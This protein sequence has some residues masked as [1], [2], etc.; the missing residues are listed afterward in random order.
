VAESGVCACSETSTSLALSTPCA[1]TNAWGICH[2]LNRCTPEGLEGCDALTPTEDLCNGVDDDCDG[3]ID[4]VDCDDGNPCTLGDTCSDGGCTSTTAKDCDDGNP[5]TTDY[6]LPA[7]GC[8][9]EANAAPCNDGDV[10]TLGDL[11]SGEA[12]QAGAESFSCDDGNPCTDDACDPTLGCVFVA[13]EAACTDIDMCTTGDQCSGGLCVSVG[14]LDCDDENPCTKD[15]CLAF[16][17]CQYEPLEGPCSDKDPCTVEDQCE[18]DLCVSGAL[19]SCDDFNPC[20]DDL[21]GAQGDCEH[22]ANEGA[23]DDQNPCTLGDHCAAGACKIEVMLLCNDQNP[24]TLDYCDPSLGCQAIPGPGPCTD[25]DLCTLEETCAGG[26][27][28]SESSLDCDDQNPCTTDLCDP[29]LGCQHEDNDLGE[30]SCGLG[31]CAHTVQNCLGGIAQA[32]D[33]MQGAA[34]DT[35]DGVDNDCDGEVDDDHVSEQTACGTGVCASAGSTSCVGGEVEDDCVANPSPPGYDSVSC[36]LVSCP[37]SASGAPTCACDA[38]YSGTL[39]WNAPGSSWD[40]SCS[41][42]DECASD[43]CGAGGTCDDQVDG[44]SCSC[45]AG[46]DG[47][48]PDTPCTD[49]D[50]CVLGADNCSDQATCTNTLGSF[51][52]ACKAGY[53]GD[54]ITCTDVDECT[55][56]TDNCSDQATCANTPGSFGCACKAGYSGDGV[57]CTD[58]NECTSG[59][60][61]CSDQATCANTPGSFTCACIAGYSGGGATCTDDDECT[62]GTDNCAD[63]ATCTNNPG[64]FECACNDGYSGDGITCTDVDECVLETDT[65]G[66]KAECKNTPGGFQCACSVGADAYCPT[67]VAWFYTHVPQYVLEAN[68]NLLCGGSGEL[69]CGWG[70][71]SSNTSACGIYSFDT[72]QASGTAVLVEEAYMCH[73]AF[74][75]SCTCPAGG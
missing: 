34:P 15:S 17:G 20:T 4:Q 2:G 69:Y 68:C 13:N 57:T 64:G 48:G 49:D 75:I 66:E 60:D 37:P 5:C 32:C 35:C 28:S 67:Q 1:I 38:G 58:V 30:T 16:A 51:T 39:T 63:T 7:E 62:L 9:H 10:C 29:E 47:G 18:G 50:E 42:I 27:C 71:Y 54:G 24:C 14:I 46:Y 21:C 3:E 70:G 73:L 56:G 55:S 44:F 11:C 53:N 31:P 59:T 25:N 45:D 6:C 43:P 26:L 65:C 23:C 74:E 40:G 12:C 22:A 41:D 19:K 52:C 36:A 33:P 72:C 8:V 61:N